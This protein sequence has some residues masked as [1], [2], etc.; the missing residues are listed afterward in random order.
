MQ[1]VHSCN[2]CPFSR[3]AA[4][5]HKSRNSEEKT[6]Q[7][8]YAQFGKPTAAY[9]GLSCHYHTQPRLAVIYGLF[10]STVVSNGID[11]ARLANTILILFGTT[12]L[13]CKTG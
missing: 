7:T 2:D 4:S 6:G 13:S 5:Y 9:P 3:N 12:L 11:T 8:A 1:T 10:E